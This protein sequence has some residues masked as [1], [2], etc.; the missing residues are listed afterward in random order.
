MGG[1]NKVFLD[2]NLCNNIELRKTPSDISVT[3][4]RVA[5]PR[6]YNRDETDFIQVVAWRN[7]AD[8]ISRNFVMGDS[9]FIEG[10]L[11]ARQYEKNG[12][13]KTVVEVVA[14]EVYFVG[15]A[16]KRKE[17]AQDNAPPLP[18]EPAPQAKAPAVYEEMTPDE[19]LP[20]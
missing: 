2:G 19:K 15:S 3:T 16:G 4:F 8:F 18:E 11:Q 13:R 5:V 12:E 14:D 17:A 10:R 7:T 20:L 1:F 6:K 9:I